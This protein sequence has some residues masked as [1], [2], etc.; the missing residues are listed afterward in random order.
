MPLSSL[1][2]VAVMLTVGGVQVAALVRAEMLALLRHEAAAY[3]LQ[4]GGASRAVPPLVPF[5]LDE[6]AQVHT[7]TLSHLSRQRV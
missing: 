6:L 5:S 2:S 3:P 1:V 4:P 7:H